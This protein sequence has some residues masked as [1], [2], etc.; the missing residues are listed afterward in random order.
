MVHTYMSTYPCIL[1][2]HRPPADERGLDYVGKDYIAIEEPKMKYSFR[3][4]GDLRLMPASFRAIG[5]ASAHFT[6]VVEY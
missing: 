5:L 1:A 3:S 6:V 4:T 2:E